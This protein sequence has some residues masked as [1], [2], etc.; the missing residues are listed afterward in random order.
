M[1]ES[2]QLAPP[3]LYIVEITGNDADPTSAP[4]APSKIQFELI[5]VDNSCN[6]DQI[7]VVEPIA[8]ITVRVGDT[9][10]TETTSFVLSS[11]VHQC[12]DI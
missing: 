7:V 9:P 8:D 3:G 12:Q 1:T 10:A 5:L 4:P 2:T 11:D 6:I